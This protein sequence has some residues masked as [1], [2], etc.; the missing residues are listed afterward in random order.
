M[1][2]REKES[3]MKVLLVAMAIVVVGLSVGCSKT[4]SPNEEGGCYSKEIGWDACEDRNALAELRAMNEEE[5]RYE[6]DSARRQGYDEGYED[7]RI[8]GCEELGDLLVGDGILD[9]YEC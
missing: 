8:A 6:V 9:W 2:V 3:E 1:G 4:Q 7:G 5:Q